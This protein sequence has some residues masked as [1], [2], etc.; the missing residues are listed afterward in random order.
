MSKLRYCC[1]L[2]L[3]LGTGFSEVRAQSD[4]LYVAVEPC[5][6]ADTRQGP[7][8][9][10]ANTVRTFKVLGSAGDL[11]AQGG[12]VDC[13]NPR[14]KPPVAVAAYV[15]AV[16]TESSSGQGVLSAY[17]SNLD[18]PPVGSGSTV[19]FRDAPI[20]NTTIVSVCSDGVCPEGGELAIISRNSDEHV[21]IDVQGY[22]YPSTKSGATF[23]EVPS[24]DLDGGPF[25]DV[26]SVSL[27]IPED[28]LLLLSYTSNATFNGGTEVICGPSVAI[29]AGFVAAADVAASGVELVNLS[30]NA[31]IFVEAGN[32]NFIVRCESDGAVNLF[33]NVLTASFF[34][35]NI[36]AF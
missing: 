32:F 7:G 15:L 11:V 16:P 14:S 21:V 35:N 3:L 31:A 23:A 25:V 4:L 36:G 2:A 18:P 28:G 8:F 5:R 26:V 22:F 29:D 27:I 10:T 17:P 1:A 19:N 30:A 34:A 6:V 33:R 12:Q 20:G 9:I 24:I 13:P